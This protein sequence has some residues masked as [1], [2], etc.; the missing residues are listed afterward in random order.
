M[1]AKVLFFTVAALA[2][3]SAAALAQPVK[4]PAGAEKL[5]AN[6]AFACSAA[7]EGKVAEPGAI[8]ALA[9]KVNSEVNRAIRPR[10]DRSQ[11]GVEEKW[12]LPVNAGDCEDYALLKMQRLIQ[13]GVAPRKLRLAQVMK[14]GVPSHVVLVVETASQDEY[15]L[16][17][18]TNSVTRRTASNYVF[19]K[20]QSRTRPQQWEAAI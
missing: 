1:S 8:L 10:S 18:L 4:T 16:D 6:Y 15:V 3:T 9:K 20:Q 5:C 19:L 14:R 2:A 11:Y 13:Q 12:V 17:S 7:A